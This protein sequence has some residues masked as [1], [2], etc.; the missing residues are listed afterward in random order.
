M[1]VCSL[2]RIHTDGQPV[3]N[4]IVIWEFAVYLHKPFTI[5]VHCVF[6]LEKFDHLW[7]QDQN[8]IFS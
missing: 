5:I 7:P 3:L 1:Y 6:I 2:L 4:G 8:T